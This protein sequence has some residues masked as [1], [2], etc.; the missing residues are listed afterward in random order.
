MLLL[1]SLLYSY[2]YTIQIHEHLIIDLTLQALIWN[3]ISCYD[4]DTTY[5]MFYVYTL[6]FLF[7]TYLTMTF[8]YNFDSI[9]WYMITNVSIKYYF[10]RICNLPMCKLYL[11]MW[12]VIYERSC[13][14]KSLVFVD[15]LLC[16]FN[17]YNYYYYYYCYH[18]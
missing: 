10:I 5:V 13:L 1:L 12:R 9:I 4:V 14:I 16:L 6:V 8:R 3:L 15:N 2:S 11:K 17:Y 18:Y 7:L